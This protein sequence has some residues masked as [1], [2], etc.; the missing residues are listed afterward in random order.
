MTEIER[1]HISQWAENRAEEVTHMEDT[2][3][4]RIQRGRAILRDK[5]QC[6]ECGMTQR[7]HKRKYEKGLEVHHITPRSEFDE[8][9]V[10]MHA[11]DNLKTV[12]VSC[13]RR[14]E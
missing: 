14:I 1:S 3:N 12:C 4:W 6:T 13:H 8:E 7:E 10:E 11:L 5:S 9:G 2:G